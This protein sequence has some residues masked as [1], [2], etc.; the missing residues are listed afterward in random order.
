MLINA[1]HKS[2]EAYY[3]KKNIKLQLIKQVKLLKH[4]IRLDIY[5][6]TK[7]VIGLFLPRH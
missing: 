2:T 4:K 3:T 1:I 7:R 5:N 6:Y